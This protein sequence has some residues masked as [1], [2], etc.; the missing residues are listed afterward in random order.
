ML[1]LGLQLLKGLA[2]L[3]QDFVSPPP[4]LAAKIFPL[5]LIHEGF[6]VGWFVLVDDRF[7]HAQPID[8]ALSGTALNGRA[9]RALRVSRQ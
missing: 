1:A 3:T 2:A 4:Q 9:Y 5:P 8:I 7:A 6:S